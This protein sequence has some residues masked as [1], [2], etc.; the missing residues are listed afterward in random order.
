MGPPSLTFDGEEE[1]YLVEFGL[2]RGSLG[3]VQH[4]QEAALHHPEIAGLLPWRVVNTLKP[5]RG[6]LSNIK[7]HL[8]VSDISRIRASGGQTSRTGRLVIQRGCDI[9]DESS[10][11]CPEYH[12]IN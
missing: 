3:Q 5:C 1:S 10:L 4:C 2:L 7:F 9:P 6:H 11:H 12:F 8:D